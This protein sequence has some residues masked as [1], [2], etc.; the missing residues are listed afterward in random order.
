MVTFSSVESY[1]TAKFL[2]LVAH[3][4]NG[5]A[6]WPTVKDNTITDKSLA[7]NVIALLS[8][9]EVR[10]NVFEASAVLL[11]ARVLGLIPPAGK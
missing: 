4:D 3:L 11:S 9:G 5:G 2:H 1:F 6:F 10:S 7:S 8:L